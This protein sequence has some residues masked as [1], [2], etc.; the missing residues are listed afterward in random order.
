MLCGRSAISMLFACSLFAA[1]TFNT[2]ST[3]TRAERVHP[4]ITAGTEPSII[5][6]QSPRSCLGA[7]LARFTPWRTR[8]KSVLQE[9]NPKIDEECSFGSAILPDRFITSATFEPASC[10]PATRP[11][12]RC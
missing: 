8:L 9:T 2:H 5:Q 1:P 10:R 3:E 7:T 4:L 12:L 6:P 11:P